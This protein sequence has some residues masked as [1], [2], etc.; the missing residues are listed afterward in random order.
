MLMFILFFWVGCWFGSR[1]EMVWKRNGRHGFPL[2]GV[3]GGLVVTRAA[4]C[5]SCGAGLSCGESVAEIR[6]AG[7]EIRMYV[8]LS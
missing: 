1:G 5:T 4:L 8:Q 2:Q 7:I 6:V 3:R